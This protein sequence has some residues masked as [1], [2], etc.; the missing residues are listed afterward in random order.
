MTRLS[1]TYVSLA[2]VGTELSMIRERAI[3]LNLNDKS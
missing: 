1:I 2:G 3:I